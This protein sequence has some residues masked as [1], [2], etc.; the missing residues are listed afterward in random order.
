MTA[1]ARQIKLGAF[2][3]QTGHHIAAWRHPGAQAAHIV[4]AGVELPSE[5]VDDL[6]ILA[7]QE[8]VLERLDLK[9]QHRAHLL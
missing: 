5:L 3:M 6:R 7:A 8:R 1:P 2:L 4:G 9:E